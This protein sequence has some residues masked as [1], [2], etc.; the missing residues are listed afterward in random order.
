MLRNIITTSPPCVIPSEVSL[1]LEQDFEDG[2][3][4][5]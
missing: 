1:I 3:A 4:S 2:A 5:Q